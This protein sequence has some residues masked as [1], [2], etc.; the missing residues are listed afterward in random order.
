VPPTNKKPS[1][2]ED[3]AYVVTIKGARER[4][5]GKSHDLIYELI[6][7]GELTSYLDGRRRLI[8]TESIKAYVERKLAA[9]KT[10]ERARYPGGNNEEAAS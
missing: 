8:T 2:P 3:S 7:T 6:R 10:F 5:G 1:T 9:A 4:L